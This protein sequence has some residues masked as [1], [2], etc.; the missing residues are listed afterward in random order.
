MSKISK[1]LSA[2][3]VILESMPQFAYVFNKQSELIMWNK[4]LELVLGYTKEELYKK[5]VFEFMEESTVDENTEAIHNIFSSKEEQSLEQNILTKSGK[6]IPVIDT[7]N[8]AFIDG[9]EYLIG[10]AVDISKLRKTQKELETQIIKTN[11]LKQLLETENINLRKEIRNSHEFSDFIG[12]SKIL[13]NT[14]YQL[15]QVAKTNS[16]VLIQ[17]EIGTRK[18]FYA[19]SLYNQSNRKDKSFIKISCNSFKSESVEKDFY[20]FLKSKFTEVDKTEIGKYKTINICTLFFEDINMFPIE[21]HSKLLNSLKNGRFEVNGNPGVIH[22]DARVIASCSDN[23][24]ELVKKNLFSKD[25]FFY[26][27]TFPIAI[28]PLR[29]RI[30]DIPILVG[31]FLTQFNKKY[32]KHIN[33]VPKKNM[34]LLQNYSWPGNVKELENLIERSVILSTTS[35]LKIQPFVNKEQNKKILTLNV[36]EREYIIKILNMT[37]WRVAGKDGAAKIL[38]LHPETLRSKMRKL[39]ISKHDNMKYNVFH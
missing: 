37:Y 39:Q 5:N 29:E 38:G 14:L 18:E 22:L 32:G 6:K 15:K 36:F 21:F 33:K 25:L 19:R 28:P 4:H 8:Y 13:L 23:L 24:E 16:T 34:E 27:N 30:S 9:E 20:A 10:M 1:V 17:G 12:K 11:Q 26:L 7:A 2:S 31:N 3:K 35:L